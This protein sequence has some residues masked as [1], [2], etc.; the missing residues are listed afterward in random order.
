[1]RWSIP[2]ATGKK[3]QK[4]IRALL[5]SLLLLLSTGFGNCSGPSVLENLYNIETDVAGGIAATSDG[6]VWFISDVNE[7]SKLAVD[8]TITAY[9]YTPTSI[10]LAG[11]LLVGPDGNL[12]TI[13]V[14]DNE[15][16]KMTTA[17]VFSQYPITTPAASYGDLINGPDGNLW[18]TEPGNAK[19]AKITT[20]GVITEYS[21]TAAHS[22]QG[23]A[24]DGTLLY[25]PAVNGAVHTIFKSYNTSGVQQ[26]STDLGAFFA[27]SIRY[28]NDGNFWIRTILGSTSV[29]KT[30]PAG[31]P[32]ALTI[33][34]EGGVD[35]ISDMIPVADGFL[36]TGN[37][38]ISPNLGA[39]IAKIDYQNNVVSVGA[40]SNGTSTG[41]ATTNQYNPFGNNIYATFQNGTPTMILIFQE[42]DP[43]LLADQNVRII[44]RGE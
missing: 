33:P 3:K 31:V 18:F 4:A 20:S 7:I 38:H 30:T 17:G 19:I 15:I 1:M 32:T 42:T 28:G 35:T 37:F 16:I 13:S 44:L 22:P 34:L 41:Y 43:I 12:W 40:T 10:G 29:L 26:A 39:S 9:T 36:I 6:N 8:G 27:G 11:P 24:T 2:S 5:C 14:D 25:V 21:I 23:I